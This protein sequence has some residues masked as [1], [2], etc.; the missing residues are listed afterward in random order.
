MDDFYDDPV[1]GRLP[2]MRS[3]KSECGWLD[4]VS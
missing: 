4:F 3:T 2:L 1:R